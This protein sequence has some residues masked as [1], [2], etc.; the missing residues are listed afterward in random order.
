[1]KT[2]VL[3]TVWNE[4]FQAANKS[5]PG[6]VESRPGTV[7]ASTSD[8]FGRSY[9][10]I[11]S[12]KQKGA[13]GFQ[14]YDID[15]NVLDRSTFYCS[16]PEDIISQYVGNEMGGVS[17]G[18]PEE[19]NHLPFWRTVQIPALCTWLKVEYLPSAQN[20]FN[21]FVQN[22]SNETAF[23]TFPNANNPSIVDTLGSDY[24]VKHASERIIFLQFEDPSGTPIIAKHGDCFKIPCNTLYVT[25]K[26]WSPKIRITLGFNTE[27]V[28][29]DDRHLTMAPAY[30]PGHGLL[31]NPYLHAVPFS[32]NGIDTGISAL[33]R[34]G[35]TS[36]LNP[37]TED[38][39]ANIPDPTHN[40]NGMLVGWIT[41][42]S[43]SC[44]FSGTGPDSFPGHHSLYVASYP[45]LT[46]LRKVCSVPFFINS[47]TTDNF[48]QSKT[49]VE[50]IRFTLH[51]GEALVLVLNA[52]PA[53]GNTAYHLFSVEGYT[54]GNIYS[55]QNTGY[56]PF[57]PQY[58]L[59][60]E[61]YPQD[62]NYTGAPNK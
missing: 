42:F 45:S 7:Y 19:S 37:L 13:R 3:Q 46:L 21:S 29:T 35:T 12:I 15:P 39:I 53:S 14:T 52:A 49:F 57:I 59:T 56:T 25:F 48:H 16:I 62:R 26:A 20:D 50:P 5:V 51:S 28:S 18:F 30:G 8:P 32:I 34:I 40:Q 1:M 55:Y 2:G 23:P 44:Y 54:F 11:L 24:T 9:D 36:A 10:E 41:S 61:P 58:K 6:D 22:L 17:L 47:A 31:G 60:Q 33:G 4:L 27:I 38:L 43:S